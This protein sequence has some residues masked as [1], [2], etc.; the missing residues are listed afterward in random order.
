MLHFQKKRLKLSVLTLLNFLMRNL[1]YQKALY[2]LNNASTNLPK[3]YLKR[4]FEIT[5]N[6]HFGEIFWE[7]IAKN[8]KLTGS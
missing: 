5:P 8:S 4:N 1:F 3:I 2:V 6:K 7:Y